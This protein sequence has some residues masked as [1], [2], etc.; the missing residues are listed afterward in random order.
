MQSKNSFKI[1]YL[2]FVRGWIA[3]T[4][5]WPFRVRIASL[6]NIHLTFTCQ[7]LAAQNKGSNVPVIKLLSK[8]KKKSRK[9]A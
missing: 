1:F 3:F 6:Y 9:I 8:G 7:P 2:N 5:A 4:I